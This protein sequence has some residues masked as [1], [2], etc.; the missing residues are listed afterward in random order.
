M[1][2]SDLSPDSDEAF[3]IDVTVLRAARKWRETQM[4]KS[5]KHGPLGPVIRALVGIWSR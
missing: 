1:G 5:A 2:R 4:N 3:A